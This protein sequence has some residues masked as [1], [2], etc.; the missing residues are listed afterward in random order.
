MSQ[1]NFMG[2]VVSIFENCLTI[3]IIRAI[4][5]LMKIKKMTS[6]INLPVEEFTTVNP[7]TADE[8]THIEELVRLMKENGI[9]HLPILKNGKPVGMI[10]ERDLKVAECFFN[11][12]HKKIVASDI[13]VKNPFTVQATTT[14]DEVAYQMSKNKIGS[15]LVVDKSNELVGIFTSTDALNA[16]IETVRGTTLS[17]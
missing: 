8:Q 16:L 2:L 14:L 3:N 7:I 5:L 13:M 12:N 4:S 17:D 1:T 15:A 9:R 6:Q 11:T 10:S